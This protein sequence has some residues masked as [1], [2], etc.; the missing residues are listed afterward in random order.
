M[1]ALLSRLAM[2]HRVAF[3]RLA[4]A[5]V[6]LGA[7]M[8]A[9]APAYAPVLHALCLLFAGMLAL[10]QPTTSALLWRGAAVG[11][12]LL[13]ALVGTTPST[14]TALLLACT[15]LGVVPG[16]AG[17]ARKALGVGC[18]LFAAWWGARWAVPVV[19]PLGAS[20]GLTAVVSGALVGLFAG[21][22]LLPL[23][24]ELPRAH[25]EAS[26]SPLL[27]VDCERAL[28]ALEQARAALLRFSPSERPPMDKLL[29]GLDGQLDEAARA[30]GA[31]EARV[32]QSGQQATSER[33]D[34]LLAQA[35]DA[36]DAQLKSEL[37]RAA[38]VLGDA[39]EAAAS[40]LR[41]RERL[42]AGVQ[43][44]VAKLERL[45]LMLQLGPSTRETLL[46]A[47]ARLA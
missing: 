1:N 44:Q 16:G 28:K 47:A 23:G 36:Q 10:E 41:E 22:A 42:R 2:P 24:L 4:L 37:E 39:L 8:G 25:F 9:L 32:A 6:V 29:L 43:V 45:S 7:L 21:V 19:L 12:A 14:L 5:S 26:L 34:A 27:P 38:L 15:G 30:L 3:E 13:V 33:R 18:G 35:D 40:L 17:L 46:S 20:A 31:V 11:V